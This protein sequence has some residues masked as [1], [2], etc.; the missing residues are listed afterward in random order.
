[1]NRRSI[2][3]L[4]A[5]AAL[6]TAL[7]PGGAVAQQARNMDGVKAASKAFYAALAVLDNGEAMEK[8]WAHRPYVTYVG[9][10]AKTIIVGW[11][12]QKKYWEDT[13]KL[14]SQRNVT[15]SDQHIH[16]NG[17]LAWEM[18][19]E[20]GTPKMKD[21]K[22]ATADY[23]VTNVYEKIGGRWPH[24]FPPRAAEASVTEKQHVARE[25]HPIPG[26][27]QRRT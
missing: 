17:N 22:D 26:H 16:I 8:V 20:S 25:I 2:L 10:R 4:S 21:G 3:G 7:L 5:T 24:G 14:F 1:M 15:L 6:G 11:D 9:P 12:A 23:I 19:Q 18:G 27:N 13:N